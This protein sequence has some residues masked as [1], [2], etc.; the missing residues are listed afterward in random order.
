MHYRRRSVRETLLS[1]KTFQSPPPSCTDGGWWRSSVK[2]L[3]DSDESV[4]FTMF[5]SRW[6]VAMVI[7]MSDLNYKKYKALKLR[8]SSRVPLE[9]LRNSFL[10]YESSI[11][12]SIKL[13]KMSDIDSPSCSYPLHIT[14]Q[15]VLCFGYG[16]VFLQALGK[17]SINL[18]S[19]SFRWQV[20][21]QATH[22]SRLFDATLK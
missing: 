12:S 13:K 14:Y 4:A 22:C 16:Y 9:G 19:N 10:G 2:P 15:G 11:I 17:S 8:L 20:A 1:V 21:D 5:D 7:A 3:D 18:S 6:M